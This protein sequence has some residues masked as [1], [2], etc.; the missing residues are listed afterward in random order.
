MSATKVPTFTAE[1]ALL[2]TPDRYYGVLT[3]R[4]DTEMVETAQLLVPP[5]F[6]RQKAVGGGSGTSVPLTVRECLEL[7]GEVA[8][9][10]YCQGTGVKCRVV[11][12][13]GTAHESC[14]TEA[15]M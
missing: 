8:L 9:W 12:R 10:S 13:D 3:A 1:A 7:G 11:T 2:T 15:T 14:I 6:Q 4:P 5:R